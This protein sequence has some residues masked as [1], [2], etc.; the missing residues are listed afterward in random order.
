MQDKWNDELRRAYDRGYWDRDREIHEHEARRGSG[1][2]RSDFRSSGDEDYGYRRATDDQRGEGYARDYP[3][4]ER[5]GYDD[6]G[7]LERRDSGRESGYIS[8]DDERARRTGLESR[9]DYG[10]DRDRYRPDE[11]DYRNRDDRD[12]RD[13]RNLRDDRSGQRL[14]EHRDFFSR[15]GDEVRSWF[16]DDHALNRRRMDDV[17]DNR[18]RKQGWE[19]LRNPP[20]HREDDRTPPF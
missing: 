5:R 1:N 8:H 15:A 11:Y 3:P 12:R 18:E 13:D 10:S 14:S 16:G 17:R 9:V 6:R 20:R 4:G 7:G 19:D 2:Q